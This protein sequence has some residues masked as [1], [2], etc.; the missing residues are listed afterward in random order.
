MEAVRPSRKNV[1]PR[2][3]RGRA[4]L[5]RQVGLRQ[6]LERHGSPLNKGNPVIAARAVELVPGKIAETRLKK[7]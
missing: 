6:D 1:P 3:E 5:F 4:H 7:K 2:V